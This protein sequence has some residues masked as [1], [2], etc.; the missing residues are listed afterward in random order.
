MKYCI[1]YKKS[2]RTAIEQAEELLIQYNEKKD[3]LE[4]LLQYPQKRIIIAFDNINLNEEILKTIIIIKKENKDIQMALR[5]QKDIEQKLIDEMKKNKIDFFLNYYA[6][7]LDIFWGLIKMGVS[8]I[9]IT[10]DLGY[11]LITIKQLAEKENI[12]IRAFPNIAQSA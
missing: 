1:T 7:N 12:I 9:Y 5:V 4:C 10:E 11:N 3:F 2:S 6:Y 8:D